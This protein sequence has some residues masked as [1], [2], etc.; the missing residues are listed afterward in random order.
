MKILYRGDAIFTGTDGSMGFKKYALYRIVC[1]ECE[2]YVML[3]ASNNKRC[4]YS[5]MAKM[6]ENWQLRDHLEEGKL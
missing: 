6:S 5:S 3:S 1:F 2:D 4:P